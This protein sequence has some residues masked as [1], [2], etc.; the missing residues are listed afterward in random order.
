MWVSRSQ[1]KRVIVT[2]VA[3]RATVD[4]LECSFGQLPIAVCAVEVFRMVLFAHGRHASSR[5]WLTTDCTK[6]SSPFVIMLFAVRHSLVFEETA[7]V[8]VAAAHLLTRT[9]KTDRHTRLDERPTALSHTEQKSCLHSKM[10]HSH[11]FNCNNDN[12][13][14]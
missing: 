4:F 7:S 14:T 6:T 12:L 8:K 10:R 3:E 1:C 5:N 9:F 2:F 11:V 13:H